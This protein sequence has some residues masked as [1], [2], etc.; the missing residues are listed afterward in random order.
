MGASA[1]HTS[2]QLA[3]T[4]TMISVPVFAL[5]PLLLV[6]LNLIGT[7]NYADVDV[8]QRTAHLSH[9]FPFGTIFHANVNALSR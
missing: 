9:I 6:K 3:I 2:A 8:L 1:S 7:V 4:G 5:Q